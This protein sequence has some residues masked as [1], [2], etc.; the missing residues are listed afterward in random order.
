MANKKPIAS[1]RT[2]I[3]NAIS[4]NATT[5]P[6][7]KVTDDEGVTMDTLLLGFIIDKG[8]STEEFIIGTVNAGAMEL[9]GVIR[10]VSVR[11]GQTSVTAL[12]QPHRKK[13]FIEITDHPYL[14]LALRQLDGT[15]Y[16]EGIPKNPL[17]RTINDPRH[18][19]DKE[20][21]EAAAA[22]AGGILA[23]Y[24]TDAGALTIDIGAGYLATSDGVIA[25]A[26]ASG[27]S[28]A[29]NSTN[30]V[31]ISNLGT[32]S[33]NQTGFTTGRLPLAIVTT[34]GG[35]ITGVSDT[36]SW[37]TAPQPERLVTTDY[38]FGATI[39]VGNHLYLDTADAKWKL[40]SA[41]SAA[42]CPGGM[43]VA[44][45]AGVN[46]DTGKRVQ[47]GGIV[48]GL[49]GLT[50]GIVYVSD[51][52]GNPSSTPGT[53]KKVIGRAI[54]ATTLVLSG[55]F[56]ASLLEGSNADVTIATI[57]EAGTFFT[58]T[59]FSSAEAETLTLG[60]GSNADSLHTHSFSA[61]LNSSNSGTFITRNVPLTI[62]SNASGLAD[63]TSPLG[64]T[65][66]GTAAVTAHAASIATVNGSG[67]KAALWSNGAAG[68]G[69]PSKET[70]L[71]H[72]GGSL[73]MDDQ[74][75]FSWQSFLDSSAGC[76]IWQGF[77]TESA[78]TFPT[79]GLCIGFFKDAGVVY[80]KTSDG[81]STTQTDITSSI[82]LGQWNDFRITRGASN[83]TFYINNVL[84][85]T[86][87]T[88]LPAS[89]AAEL[90]FISEDIGTG[91]NHAFALGT[92]GLLTH[93]RTF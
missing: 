56:D 6:I 58:G 63:D 33:V 76:D 43:A 61:L 9:T 79:T 45:E 82:T 30:Y 93:P 72:N 15:D 3:T 49:S 39:A 18:L 83:V 50:P 86:H 31:E 89:G 11:D 26:G 21:A 17:A 67:N 19:V 44:L 47:L 36:R 16:L 69:A 54:N 62:N 5:I 2:T 37:L 64:M 60:T 87:T 51:T 71:Y 92:T 80:T 7:D 90:H 91:S 10:G 23:F 74:F 13:A 65:I 28:V 29:N 73:G 38:T 35:D 78:A 22:A 1:F 75:S 70:I 20:F 24:V 32:A 88:N 12:K 40:A 41:S 14:V 59:D 57:N 53:Y 68:G 27:V 66:T 48:T 42:T 77:D 8:R 46:N 55:T 4:S 34:S 81:S 52:A 85:A 25:Y 84:V